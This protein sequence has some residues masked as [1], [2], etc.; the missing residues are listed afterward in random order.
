MIR[1]VPA[2]IVL[3]LATFF[4]A[5]NP[6]RSADNADAA[7]SQLEAWSRDLNHEKYAVRSRATRSLRKAGAKAVGL[8]AHA[9]ETSSREASYRAFHLLQ[10]FASSGVKSEETAAS[11]ALIRLAQSDE[12]RVAARALD[13][14]S[15]RSDLIASRAVDELRRLGANVRTSYSR[16]G[17]VMRVAL[18]SKWSGGDE[19]VELLTLLKSLNWLSLE[20]S[21]VT[22]ASTPVLNRLGSLEY[23]Y[24][25]QTKVSNQGI[26]HL[27]GLPNLKYL[28]LEG[29]AIDDEAMKQVSQFEQLESLGLDGTNIGDG[30]AEHLAQLT[31]LTHLWLSK[32]KVTDK[33]FARVATL[34]K[35]QRLYLEES[36]VN[37]PGIADLQQL[38]A[39]SY[40]SLKRVKLDAASMQQI[41]KLTNLT[42]LG[43]EETGVD[44][45]MVQGLTGLRNLKTLWL[46]KTTVGNEGLLSLVDLPK[47]RTVF[48]HGAKVTEAGEKQFSKQRLKIKA[49]RCTI[50]R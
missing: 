24:L 21:G 1:P 29:L 32:T 44:D 15:M 18:T 36:H 3:A 25:G 33:T 26:A 7:M 43:L 12:R 20:H 16:N 19:G 45:Q 23:L 37:G 4:A 31:N 40:L 27:E 42:I 34:K 14:L 28:S 17:P 50:H 39:L 5:E 2:I 38:P 22:N 6:V 9:A 41:A 46:S 11:A 30:S 8:I 35:L 13:I 48:L 47:L 10:E 49:T